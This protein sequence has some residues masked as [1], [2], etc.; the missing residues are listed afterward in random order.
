MYSIAHYPTLSAAECAI[1]NSLILQDLHSVFLN[2][3]SIAETFNCLSTGV[4][5]RSFFLTRLQVLAPVGAARMN[6]R[7]RAQ[8]RR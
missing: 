2:S 1:L 5:Q 4:F 6:H 8:C 3:I 7:Q